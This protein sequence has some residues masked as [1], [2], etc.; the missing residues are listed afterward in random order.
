MAELGVE[1]S[2][3]HVHFLDREVRDPR[4]VRLR[5]EVRN[6][7][8]VHERGGFGHTTSANDEPATRSRLD[9]ER[10]SAAGSVLVDTGTQLDHLLDR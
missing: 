1:A 4:G 10:D 5:V 7:C 6:K 2:G 8:A 9:T 3:D